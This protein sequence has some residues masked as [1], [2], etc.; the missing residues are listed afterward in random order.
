MKEVFIA[1][2]M[3]GA[4]FSVVV[5]LALA[6]RAGRITFLQR[7]GEFAGRQAHLPA[8]V[9]FPSAVLVVSLAAAVFGLYWDISLHLSKGRD[10][11]PLANPSHYFILL[12][13][14]G[15]FSA[16]VFA[17]TFPKPGTKP[18]PF[19]IKLAN[20][21]YAPLGGVLIALSATFGLIGFPL[22]DIWHRMFGQDVTLWGPTH[23]L[24]L[25]GASLTLVGQA[26]L[27]VEGMRSKGDANLKGRFGPRGD[28]IASKI[29]KSSAAGGLL[30]ALSIYQGEFDFGI[31]QFQMIFHPILIMVAAG[32]ALTFA[33]VWA[34]RGGALFA[35]A[36]FLVIRG[37]LTLLVTEVLNRPVAHFPL[38]IG[39]ALA[40]E[41]VG[42]FMA[43]TLREKPMRFAAAAGAAVGTLGLASEWAWTHVWMIFPWPSALWPEGAIAGFAAAIAASFI[44][45]WMA[46]SLSLRP[47]IKGAMRFAPL[48][49]ALVIAAL[50]GYG[51]HQGKNPELTAQVTT[52]TVDTGKPGKWVTV[53]A[54]VNSDALD[55]DTKWATALAWQGPGLVNTK[56]VHIA[57]GTYRT[58]APVPVFGKWKTVMRWHNG[59]RLIGM[60][61]YEPRDD[62]IPA[63]EVP[64][65]PSFTRELSSDRKILQRESKV[66]GTWVP[67]LGYFA[68]LAIALLLLTSLAW[69][70][71]RVSRPVPEDW[72]DVDVSGKRSTQKRDPAQPGE[73]VAA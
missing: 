47:P 58:A 59:D 44:G 37:V 23:L 63:A 38:F 7:A 20:D 45:V 25:A 52:Q 40:V 62:A 26:I 14:L 13:L 50:V 32:L 70:I 49:G 42:I 10:P 9:A 65:T 71:W 64:A 68:I 53:T 17:M 3:V 2:A 72:A 27:L 39:C 34:G 69:G 24:M 5:L 73:P 67:L 28:K 15:V 43:D 56:L 55:N 6:H 18:S 4:V 57:P 51:L 61:I 33:R 35:A 66:E 29:R 1:S 8:W 22:D 12:G 21:W 11:G 19:A 16:G 36:F 31:P 48:A 46:N 60:A 54:H 41:L 30:I